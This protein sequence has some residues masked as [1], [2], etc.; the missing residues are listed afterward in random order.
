MNLGK[1]GQ[2]QIYKMTNF[3]EELVA[4]DCFEISGDIFILTSDFKKDGSRYCL[5]LRNG[6]FRWFKSDTITTKIGIFYTDKDG[7]IIALKELNKND[8]NA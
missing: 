2:I 4:G 7:N 6:L 3:V 1:I 5:N 8:V